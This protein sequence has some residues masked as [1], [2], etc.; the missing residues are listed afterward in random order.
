MSALRSFMVI[1][2]RRKS[3]RSNV[4]MRFPI[5]GLYFLLFSNLRCILHR[6][7]DSATKQSKIRVFRRFS[8]PRL[9]KPSQQCSRVTERT[10]YGA[11]PRDTRV[12]FSRFNLS[13][14]A[15][16]PP[17]SQ[18]VQVHAAHSLYTLCLDM[19]KTG[20]GINNNCL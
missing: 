19:L 18:T 6:L 3:Y 5:S 7:R 14:R 1:Q 8:R 10:K 13:V 17:N 15:R 20:R 2:G 9:V 16:Q 11:S 4:R 12:I